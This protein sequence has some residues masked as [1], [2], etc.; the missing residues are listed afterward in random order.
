[1]IEFLQYMKD[2]IFWDVVFFGWALFFTITV[3]EMMVRDASMRDDT[4]SDHILIE[5]FGACFCWAMFYYFTH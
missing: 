5:K 3:I 1:M 2:W 4:L